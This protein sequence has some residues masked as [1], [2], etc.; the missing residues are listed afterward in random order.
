MNII[1]KLTL[2]HL[3]EN[4]KRSF[5]TILGI[6]FSTALISAIF[7]G[8]FS[9]LKFMGNMSVES[10]G[11]YEG[12]FENPTN[13]QIV[14]L[15][16]DEKIDKVG[17]FVKNARNA[18]FRIDLD[19]HDRFR[20]GSI[21]YGNTDYFSQMFGD[22][23]KGRLPK[24]SGEIALDAAFLMERGLDV[25]VGDTFTFEEGGRFMPGSEDSVDNGYFF[26]RYRPDE[27]FHSLGEKTCIVTAIITENKAKP[28]FAMFRGIDELGAKEDTYAYVSL[29]KVDHTS[30]GQLNDIK[31]KYGLEK[32]EYNEEYLLSL[33]CF[34]DMGESIFQFFGVFFIGL[35]VVVL[36]SIV[37]IYNS[38]AMSLAEKVKYLGM[39][40][41]VGAT[42]AQK[43]GSIYFEGLILAVI[44]IPL[45]ILMGI[46]G[47]D[48]TLNFLGPKLLA[49]DIFRVMDGVRGSIPLYAPVYIIVFIVLIAVITVFVSLSVP[50][51]KASKIMPVD[52]LR[53]TGEIK[54]KAKKLRINPLIRMIF[55]YEGELAYK[56]IKRNGR[57]GTVITF[58][59]GAAIVMF[60]TTTFII[61]T[62]DA[63]NPYGITIP[64]DVAVTCGYDETD[65]L[66][67]ALSTVPGINEIHMSD[68]I[69]FYYQNVDNK[70]NFVPANKDILNTDYLTDDY[71]WLFDRHGMIDA[72]VI[73]D[74]DFTRIAGE[75]GYDAKALMEGDLKGLLVDTYYCKPSKKGVF[76][77]SIIG[78][79]LFYDDS[80]N[81]PPMVTIAG[82]VKFNP[83][84][85]AFKVMGKETIAV[86]ISQSSYL[87]EKCKYTDLSE[88]V[89]T[90]MISTDNNKEVI[91]K[92]SDILEYDGYHHSS[93]MNITGEMKSS[94]AVLMMLKTMMYGFTILV[95]LIVIAN[96]VNSISTGVLLRRKEFAM[97]RS[98]G[99]EE[100][101]FKRMMILESFLY[102]IRGVVIGVPVSVILSYMIYLK[103]ENHNHA[104]FEVNVAV[105]AGVVVAVFA[106]VGVSMLFSTVKIKNDNII[107]ALKDDIC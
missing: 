62:A 9:F 75:N 16:N 21:C 33:L 46:L 79:R 83:D 90:I 94:M 17:I 23:Y 87:R 67:E 81:N 60:L 22:K 73:E 82:L 48:A 8:C 27:E 52:A 74:E 11:N 93:V 84:E 57:K 25:K 64:C 29:K 14:Q 2:R 77:D 54:V 37:L 56:N 97:Y 45:G 86:L 40:A 96:L 55:G 92:V 98:V 102:G 43:R 30:A 91:E 59:I 5:I 63:A 95:S 12:V 39:L 78:A 65:R 68:G 31:A 36:V 4:K 34:K 49:A 28:A 41:S 15:Q 50:A 103:A 26:G 38:I 6:A 42:K 3:M 76:N 19:K 51:Y 58:T 105:Y 35:G 101:G 107:E 66:K 44:G 53:Q 72:I 47:S 13:E 104:P 85:F 100:K 18:G 32:L 99:M 88:L 10:M 80:P 24:N 20:V 69:E 7:I 70:K 106:I 61:E 89:A 71:K 1:Q